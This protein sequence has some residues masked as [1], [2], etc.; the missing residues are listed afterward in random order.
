MCLPFRRGWGRPKSCWRGHGDYFIEA[1]AAAPRVLPADALTARQRRGG[2][3]RT[4]E[5]R[6]AVKSRLTTT[7]GNPKFEIPLTIRRI[8]PSTTDATV[9]NI[10]KRREKA[11]QPPAML[12]GLINPNTFRSRNPRFTAA[13]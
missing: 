6:T 11:A 10:A 7:C 13:H 2:F 3:R 9:A 12:R 5:G 8:R 4:I 1:G